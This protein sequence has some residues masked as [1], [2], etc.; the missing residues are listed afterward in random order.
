MSKITNDG[1]TRPGVG[2]YSCIH[3][4]PLGVKGLTPVYITLNG[5]EQRYFNNTKTGKKGSRL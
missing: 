1:L 2:C 5:V 3:V 4:A